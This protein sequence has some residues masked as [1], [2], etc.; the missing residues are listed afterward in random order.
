MCAFVHGSLNA[1]VVMWDMHCSWYAQI[2]WRNS[3][4][5]FMLTIRNAFNW[6]CVHCSRSFISLFFRSLAISFSL[7]LN[8]VHFL[9]RMFFFFHA[10]ISTYHCKKCV[11]CDCVINVHIPL[12]LNS[13]TFTVSTLYSGK[14]NKK[15]PSEIKFLGHFLTFR[16]VFCLLNS[17]QLRRLRTK[18]ERLSSIY[19]VSS[20]KLCIADS[21]SKRKRLTKKNRYFTGDFSYFSSISSPGFFH[22]RFPKCFNG[23]LWQPYDMQVCKF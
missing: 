2:N 16:L 15:K 3:S 4:V 9:C 23:H 11:R 19:I 5:S 13:F 17:A 14:T 7:S 8:F 18:Y 20:W 1:I 10:P 21:M 6:K 22:S 12:Q